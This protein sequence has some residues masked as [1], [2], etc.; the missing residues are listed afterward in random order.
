MISEVDPPFHAVEIR[1]AGGDNEKFDKVSSINLNEQ[2]YVLMLNPFL[3]LCFSC[4]K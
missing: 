3:P 4:N 2:R 1:K